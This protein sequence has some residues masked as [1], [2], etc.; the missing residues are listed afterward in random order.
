[1]RFIWSALMVSLPSFFIW[2]RRVVRKASKAAFCLV[3]S[4]CCSMSAFCLARSSGL[5]ASCAVA[6]NTIQ[7]S[8]D[9][10]GALTWPTFILKAAASCLA[11]PTSGMEPD[12]AKE[13]DAFTVRSSDLATLSTFSPA[14]ARLE[15]SW[16]RAGPIDRFF[17]RII[18]EDAV[19][20]FGERALM[21][22]LDI[23]DRENHEAA[24]DLDGLAEFAGM[25]AEQDLMQLRRIAERQNRIAGG[26][27]RGLADIEMEFLG[28]IVERLAIG[29]ANGGGHLV[30][31]VVGFGADL[32]I[33]NRL[34]NGVVDF[35]ESSRVGGFAVED[36]DDVETVLRFDQVGDRA[37]RQRERGLLKLGNGLPVNDPAEVATLGLRAVVLRIF[38]GEVLE[39]RAVLGLL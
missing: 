23:L 7:F 21:R 34:E 25:E 1:M 36:F 14:C 18:G 3:C 19:V 35:F 27:R 9:C 31:D 6:L 22:R 5:G 20:D 28:E 29:L 32:L 2:S 37:L 24:Y 30:G 17:V 4:N 13:S 8:P 33:E 38:L 11:V 16:A 15:R 26:G 10:V 12:R 39:I